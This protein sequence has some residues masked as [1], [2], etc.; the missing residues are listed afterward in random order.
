MSP[1]N[2]HPTSLVPRLRAQRAPHGSKGP[3]SPSLGLGVGYLGAGR[4]DQLIMQAMKPWLNPAYYSY[5][6]ARP[7]PT[8]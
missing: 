6:A 8:T 5:G 4:L 1:S 2:P 3:T 7:D